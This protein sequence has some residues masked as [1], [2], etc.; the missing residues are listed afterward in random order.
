MPAWEREHG[1]LPSPTFVPVSRK[2]GGHV[3]FI[4]LPTSID[5]NSAGSEFPTTED[6]TDTSF[7]CSSVFTSPSHGA[8]TLVPFTTSAQNAIFRRRILC[9]QLVSSCL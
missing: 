1:E 4:L 9:H 6:N 8:S 5:N 3:C 7:D 2:V